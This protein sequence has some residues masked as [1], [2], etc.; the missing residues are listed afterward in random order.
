MA[1][2]M[3]MAGLPMT[4][5]IQPADRL[6]LPRTPA[7]S[8]TGAGGTIEAFSVPEFDLSVGGQTRRLPA[9]ASGYHGSIGEA[10]G[11]QVDAIVGLDFLR[12]FT[13]DIDYVGGRLRLRP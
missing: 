12:Q 7:E 10:I 3:A 9:T 2:A 6:G 1:T 4:C 13:I 5:S 11:R 8:L